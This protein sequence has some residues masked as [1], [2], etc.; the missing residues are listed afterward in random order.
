MIRTKKEFAAMLEPPMSTRQLAV[1]I[2][3][4][5]VIMTGDKIDDTIVENV[6]FISRRKDK[7]NGTGHKKFDVKVESVKQ[8]K[9]EKAQLQERRKLDTTI[10]ELE[11]DRLKETNELLK[12]KK[13]KIHGTVIPVDLVKMLFDQHFKSVTISFQQGVDNIIVEISKKKKLTREETAKLREKMVKV[14]NHAVGESLK[15]TGKNL[16]AMQKQYSETRGAGERR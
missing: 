9:E 3:R 13:Q 6:E 1:H 10:K 7:K 5:E 11:V 4:G 2:N 12:L 15:N 8:S 14:I 16:I